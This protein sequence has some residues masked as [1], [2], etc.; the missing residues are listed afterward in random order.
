MINLE[1]S[2]KKLYPNK[3]KEALSQIK[4]LI[5]THHVTSLNTKFVSQND[6]MVITYGDSIKKEGEKPLKTLHQFLNKYAYPE[7]NCLHILPM[8]PYSSDDGFSVIDYEEVNQDLGTWDDIKSLS[9]SYD[10]MFDAVI[11]HISM[12]SHWFKKYQKGDPAYDN[13]FIECDVNADY[14]Q[15][16]RPRA[17]P[18]FYP[19]ETSVGE[20]HL[21]ATFSKDQLD[22]NYENYKVLVHVLKVLALYAKNG[23]RFIR[24]DA[25]GFLWKDKDTTSMHLE[26]THLLVK[27]MRY[28]L[29]QMYPGTIIIT[30]TNVPH[31]ENVSYFGKD[32]DEAHLVYQ[33]PLP[34]LT[35]YSY[36]SQNATHLSTWASQL[37]DMPLQSENTYFNFLAS[38]DG[39]GM[40]PVENI[41]NQEEKQLM[42]DHTIKNDGRIG[43]KNNP[44]GSVSPYELN[45]SYF[46]AII[47]KNDNQETRINKFIGA[48]MILLSMKGM[49][50]IYIHSLIGSRN[51]IE[52]M[53]ASGINRRINRK[54]VDYDKLKKVLDD[55]QSDRHII[56][57]KL[58]NLIHIRKQFDAF[59]PKA[60]QDIV[61]DDPRVF[62]MKRLGKTSTIEA[63]V[64][65]SD[66]T[67]TI[68]EVDGFDLLSQKNIENLV[69][70]P[71]DAKWIE[72]KVLI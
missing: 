60:K 64:N 62:K 61:I 5:D 22:L 39:I 11:N 65:V 13:Y 46:D 27:I 3:Y 54:K 4:E 10:L 31:E 55:S 30:E 12:E 43:Y 68:D 42:V 1:V 9:L 53:K 6:V 41:L 57:N 21:W 16:I 26:Q 70:K 24:F 28:V 63:Y 33:F 56:L 18:L 59:D 20:K 35:L 50:A 58:I 44:D 45:I 38:H 69:L 25:V 48:H 49:P 67:I 32:N 47:N 52:G 7:V 40:R 17:L 71:Y 36:I 37:E 51:D 23:S 15:V 8:F 34:P 29:D 2:L 14:H 66:E 19:Y 72:K